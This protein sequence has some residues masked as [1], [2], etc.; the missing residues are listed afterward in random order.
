MKYQFSILFTIRPR[1]ISGLVLLSSCHSYDLCDR[2]SL[3]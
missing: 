2:L 1:F 3:D